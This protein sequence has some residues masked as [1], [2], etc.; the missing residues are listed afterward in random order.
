MPSISTNGLTARLRREIKRMR[1]AHPRS[2]QR[3]I[4]PTEAAGIAAEV[5]KLIRQAQPDDVAAS[6]TLRG[7]YVPS[8]YKYQAES[9]EVFVHVDLTAGE[10]RVRA[11]RTWAQIR[12]H[13]V[14]SRQVNRLIREGQ[15]TG[16]V[17]T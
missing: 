5:R 4:E 6:L 1:A 7:G 14:G 8:S 12:S 10:I 13:G 3:S 9:D 16:R 11:H 15:S 2:Q 17:V